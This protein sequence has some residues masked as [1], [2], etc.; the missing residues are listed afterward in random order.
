MHDMWGAQTKGEEALSLFAWQTSQHA[1]LA[2]FITAESYSIFSALHAHLQP[3]I[4]S[5]VENPPSASNV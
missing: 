3:C 4:C 1:G 2:P 5:R